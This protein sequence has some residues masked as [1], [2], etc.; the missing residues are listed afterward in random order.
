MIIE[1]CFS[2]IIH[3]WLL[4]QSLTDINCTATQFTQFWLNLTRIASE[5]LAFIMQTYWML[6]Y[7]LY[8]VL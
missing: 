6:S 2:K 7:F 3:H 8:L 5:L 1:I 4:Q